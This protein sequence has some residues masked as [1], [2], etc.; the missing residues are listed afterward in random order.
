MNLVEKIDGFIDEAV[1]ISHDRFIRS[2]GKKN[3]NTG[4]AS[5]MF[6]NKNMGNVDYNNDKECLQVSGT[7]AEATKSAKEWGKKHGYDTVYFMEHHVEA[8]YNNLDEAAKMPLTLKIGDSFK[9]DEGTIKIT[10]ITVSSL[11][12]TPITYI[13]YKYDVVIDGKPMKG[14]EKASV[15]SFKDLFKK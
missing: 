11:H 6:T 2:H 3:T 9:T 12:T 14:E 10:D 5:W 13:T 4:Y 8:L 1:K 7:K 15:N